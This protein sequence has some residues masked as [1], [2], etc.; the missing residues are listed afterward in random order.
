[1]ALSDER[2]DIHGD[3]LRRLPPP[4]RKFTILTPEAKREYFRRKAKEYYQR[5]KRKA[6]K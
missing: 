5:K 3:A 1:M 4:R 6:A 2:W